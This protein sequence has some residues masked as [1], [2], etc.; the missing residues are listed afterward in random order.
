[1]C[2]DGAFSQP[3]EEEK[4]RGASEVENTV[5]R[6]EANA[7]RF[8]DELVQSKVLLTLES[9]VQEWGHPQ[10]LA[11]STAGSSSFISQWVSALANIAINPT[12]N[13]N[14]TNPGGGAG[15]QKGAP[16]NNGKRSPPNKEKNKDTVCP[17]LKRSGVCS[18]FQGQ[19]VRLRQTPR[20]PL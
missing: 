1:M 2:T 13:Y 6:L 7:Q 3:S 8:G 16:A 17:H 19:G 10:Q 11:F 5:H 20:R 18:F 9:L 12:A 15:K 14:G 4:A